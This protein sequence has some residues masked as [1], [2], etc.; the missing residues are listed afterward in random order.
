MEDYI[1]DAS[2]YAHYEEWGFWPWEELCP[3]TE[4]DV[5]GFTPG[6]QD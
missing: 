4:E 6:D 2:D 1:P 5:C 3:L